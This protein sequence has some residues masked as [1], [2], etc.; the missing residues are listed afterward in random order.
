MYNF[1]YCRWICVWMQ[2]EGTVEATYKGT[3]F[4][5]YT[6]EDWSAIVSSEYSP[7]FFLAPA[8]CECWVI[9]CLA[10]AWWY[11]KHPT[12]KVF[13]ISFFW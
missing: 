2:N 9:N 12:P 3:L 8:V 11:K 5:Y 10:P 7:S 13:E 1:P 6:N 4:L